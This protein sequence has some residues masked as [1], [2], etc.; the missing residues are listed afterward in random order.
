[1]II[2]PAGYTLRVCSAGHIIILNTGVN[3][4]LLLAGGSP[5]LL[6]TLGPLQTHIQ[7]QLEEAGEARAAAGH[8]QGAGGGGGGLSAQA[9][10]ELESQAEGVATRLYHLCP[11]KG[12]AAVQMRVVGGNVHCID[13][14][15][16]DGNPEPLHQI[17][18]N[19][20]AL[21]GLDSQPSTL[22]QVN[23]TS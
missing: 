13:A 19:P 3:S 17:H 23:G 22:N 8:G 16:G 18:D 15:Q 5:H 21:I 20:Y 4:S 11:D 12:G 14:V 2:Y 6:E 9:R 7:A 10:A 1:M